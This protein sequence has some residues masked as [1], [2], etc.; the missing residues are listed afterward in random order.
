MFYFIEFRVKSEETI[1]S[2]T[3]QFATF[4]EIMDLGSAPKWLLKLLCEEFPMWLSGTQLVSV[5]MRIQFLASISGLK[6][7]ALPQTVE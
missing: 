6:D 2:E 4:N 3:H 1:K 7:L 5:W